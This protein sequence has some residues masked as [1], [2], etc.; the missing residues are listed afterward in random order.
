VHEKLAEAAVHESD[1]LDGENPESMGMEDAGHWSSGYGEL[2]GF[3]ERLR[4][5]TLMR[6]R[7]HQGSLEQRAKFWS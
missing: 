6:Y 4:L 5:L 2:L 3:K 1:L 7:R